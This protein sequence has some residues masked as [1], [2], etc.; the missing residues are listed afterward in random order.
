[1]TKIART[2]VNVGDVLEVRSS[3][4]YSYVQYVGKHPEY[5]DVI[6]VF[7]G[8]FNA[9]QFDV[10]SSATHTAYLAFYSARAAVSQGFAEI[11]ETIPL[12][13]GTR[14]PSHVR[15]AGARGTGGEIRTWIIEK[16]G[17]EVVK[18]EL[19][20]SERQ[21][22]IAA[23]WDHELLTLRISEKWDPSQEG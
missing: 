14:V 18:H 3:R 1:M 4:G 5:G 2:R 13:A 23:I 16:D 22:P 6:R 7:Q 20:E 11:V 8:C 10:G 15:R 19:T 17:Q 21:L 9:R 12:P